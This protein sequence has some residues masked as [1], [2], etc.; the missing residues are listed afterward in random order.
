MAESCE[1][2][3][4]NSILYKKR[5]IDLKE[6]INSRDIV[7]KAAVNTEQA[8]DSKH[9]FMFVS[10]KDVSEKIYFSGKARLSFDGFLSDEDYK[11]AGEE[12]LHKYKYEGDIKLIGEDLDEKDWLYKIHGNFDGDLPFLLFNPVQVRISPLESKAKAE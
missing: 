10:K 4:C 3:P 11:R 7:I 2:C 9:I 5:R 8:P 12:N 1:R 6:K